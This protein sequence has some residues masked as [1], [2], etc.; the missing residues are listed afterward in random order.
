MEKKQILAEDGG[1]QKFKRYLEKIKKSR[2]FALTDNCVADIHVNKTVVSKSNEDMGEI[3]KGMYTEVLFKEKDFT[4]SP[5][6]IQFA[7]ALLREARVVGEKCIVAEEVRTKLDKIQNMKGKSGI[8]LLDIMTSPNTSMSD[9]LALQDKFIMPIVEELKQKDIEEEKEKRKKQKE[10]KDQKGKKEGEKDKGGE[11][12]ES[13]EDFDPNEFWKKDYDEADKATPNAVPKEDVEKA[14]EEYEEALKAKAKSEKEIQEELDKEYAEKIGV[15]KEDLQ[16]YRE[17]VKS[18]ENI[19][20]PETNRNVIQELRD[21]ISKIIAKRKKKKPNPKYPVE[22]GEDLI[23]PA[24]LVVEVKKG[25]FSPKVW[26]THDLKEKQD[27]KFGEIEISL[28]CDRSDSMDGEKLKEQQKA[29]VLMMEALK[30]LGDMIVEERSSLGKPLLVR[31]EIYSFQSTERDSVP[32]KPMSKELSEGDRIKSASRLGS[33]EGSTTDFVPLE[34][35]ANSINEKS[36]KKDKRRRTEKNCY[37]LHRWG[38]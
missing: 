3:E 13:S 21:L 7:E 8:S 23:E 27:N 28:V 14:L 34:T 2:A 25:N 5:K 29:A 10:Q 26:E 11:Q 17:L 38:K 6:H 33:C 18:L 24:E 32:I 35:I 20:N 31:S 1:T 9:R 36:L 4:K 22:E 12:G 30:E 19:I 16:K 37:C 15:K